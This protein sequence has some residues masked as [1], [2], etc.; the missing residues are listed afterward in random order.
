M[1]IFQIGS[2]LS[3]F[4]MY[5]S[6]LSQMKFKDKRGEVHVGRLYCC[7]GDNCN[8]IDRIPHLPVENTICY[9]G[10][11][12]HSDPES[13]AGQPVVT[14]YRLSSH[15]SVMCHGLWYVS[16]FGF[17]VTETFFL[18]SLS[19][20]K[21]LRR[22]DMILVRSLM[23]GWRKKSW[24]TERVPTVVSFVCVCLSVRNLLA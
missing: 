14:P 16:W 24:N 18:L 11:F 13:F 5:L 23:I 21:H 9:D 6:C 12:N 1:T 4:Y 8:H 15:G 10:F 7:M 20:D 17:I 22:M 2:S 3:L 19:L